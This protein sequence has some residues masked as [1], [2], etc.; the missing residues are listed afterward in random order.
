MLQY[1]TGIFDYIEDLQ[2]PE[3]SIQLKTRSM[4]KVFCENETHRQCYVL[5]VPFIYIFF[6]CGNKYSFIY[7]FI[8]FILWPQGDEYLNS[9][10]P[11]LPQYDQEALAHYNEYYSRYR[12]P[13]S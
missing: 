2:L 13:S 12:F 8:C 7:L 1:G 11:S 5:N 9:G 6:F 10:Q 4:K 3:I